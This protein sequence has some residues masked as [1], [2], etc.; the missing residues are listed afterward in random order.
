MKINFKHALILSVISLVSISLMIANYMS[1]NVLK[2]EVISSTKHAI[3]SSVETQA[4]LLQDLMD[5]QAAAL[6]DVAT[7]LS[8][9]Q[10]NNKNMFA[11]VTVA[12][13]GV[14]NI[15]IAY[16]NGNFYG[17]W[18]KNEDDSKEYDPR[19]R[20]WYQEAK[21]KNKSIFTEIYKDYNSNENVVGIARDF[22][23][24]VILAGITLDILNE[25]AI[26]AS[27]SGQY[28]SVIDQNGVFLAT[29]KSS[30]KPGENMRDNAELNDLFQSIVNKQNTSVKY[31]FNGQERFAFSY[32][33]NLG[34]KSWYILSGMSR[35]QLFA[36]VNK[37][38]RNSII[39]TLI[40]VL[41][42]GILMFSILN[43]VYKPILALKETLFN[44]S[45]GEA[46]FT[47]QLTVQ[48]SKDDLGKITSYVNIIIKNNQNMIHEIQ[49]VSKGLGNVIAN[50]KENSSTNTAI[51]SEHVAQTEQVVTAIEEMNVTSQTM[52]EN[53]AAAAT[54]THAANKV[55]FESRSVVEQAQTSVI[56]LVE[57]VQIA[58]KRVQ[59]M[60]QETQNI[61]SITDVIGGIAEQTNLLALNA[62]IEAARAG[63]QGRGFAVVAD[64][65]RAL[66]ARTQTSTSE[67]DDAV[68]SLTDGNSAVVS[69]MD[70][71]KHSCEITS[72]QTA[73]VS[74][75]LDSLSSAIEN[76]TSINEQIATAA[77]EQTSV[78]EEISK[79]MTEISNMANTVHH[80]IDN[81][82]QS[83]ESMVAMYRKLDELVGNSKV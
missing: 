56:A 66:A 14:S 61:S 35:E 20:T 10:V 80:N 48:N 53:A 55:G 3:A 32:R 44:L 49:S 71:T 68:N 63:E 40:T 45:Q 43:I 79:N 25:T 8:K 77:E 38:T 29:T 31:T 82:A 58:A 70:E 52:S 2:E 51:L 28:G 30:I 21:N 9:E 24:G 19:K 59:N 15:T 46:D 81:M 72:Q 11:N 33:V 34:D 6:D 47:K 62:A 27:K 18:I 74:N 1:H 36:K 76:I 60:S 16:H 50:M 7:I 54:E 65:V 73:M 39:T 4:L 83:V 57:E 17:T 23:K 12:S 69:A 67:I 5:D 42:A 13:M 75:S 64:E 22:G 78:S 37:S 26:E 41:A